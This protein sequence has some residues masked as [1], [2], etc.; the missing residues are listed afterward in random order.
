VRVLGAEWG[1]GFKR[2]WRRE[3]VAF[4]QLVVGIRATHY[5]CMGFLARKKKSCSKTKG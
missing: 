5:D 1:Q 4:V 3:G 2:S